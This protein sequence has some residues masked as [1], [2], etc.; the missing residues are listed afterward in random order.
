MQQL[1]GPAEPI[2][3]ALCL[4]CQSPSANQHGQPLSRGSGSNLGPVPGP[5][6]IIQNIK[7]SG[8]LL[9]FANESGCVLTPAGY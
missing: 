5:Q 9:L 7:G 4:Y 2:L 3:P 8:E 6:R 1:S